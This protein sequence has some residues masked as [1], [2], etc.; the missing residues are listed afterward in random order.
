MP[1]TYETNTTSDNQLHERIRQERSGVVL[2]FRNTPEALRRLSKNHNENTHYERERDHLR[3][4]MGFQKHRSFAAA[5]AMDRILALEQQATEEFPIDRI[6][7]ATNPH[8][9]QELYEDICRIENSY[10]NQ[11]ITLD[12]ESGAK[13]EDQRGLSRINLIKFF[14]YK[15]AKCYDKGIALTKKNIDEHILKDSEL[16]LEDIK[17]QICQLFNEAREIGKN[18]PD[19][20]LSFRAN[21]AALTSETTEPVN[22][23]DKAPELYKDRADRKENAEDFTRRVYGSWFRKGISR[24]HIKQLDKSLYGMLNKGGFPESLV[25]D[26]PAAPGRSADDLARSDSELLASRRASQR[27]SMAKI[28]T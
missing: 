4:E 1:R 19:T 25:Q 26:L 18:D 14:I 15:A 10:I 11:L 28:R 23:P 3:S 2:Q 13:F 21:V 8:K 5:K 22:I 6:L 16:R 12:H 24:P 9:N 20:F 17:K 27:R 7:A